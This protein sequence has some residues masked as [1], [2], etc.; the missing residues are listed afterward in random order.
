VQ[1]I[2]FDGQRYEVSLPWKEH[3]PPLHDHFVLCHKR[4]TNL[5]RRRQSPQLLKEYDAIIRDQLDKGIV[6]TVTEPALSVS[7]RV[8]YLPHHGV[9]R[10]DKATSKLRIVYDA[11]AK[12]TG[13]SLNDCLY[14]GPKFGQSI[15]DILLRFHLQKV[16]LTG[17][18]E[19][20]FLMVSV[21]ERDR[22]SLRFLWTANPNV[23]PPEIITLRFARVMFECLNATINHHLQTYRGADAAFVDKFLSSILRR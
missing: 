13:P 16:A 9:V 4:L 8:H 1:Q 14:T 18:I 3:H 10:Q 23:E 19:K 15:F 6:E 12:S 7:D 11:S 20:A 2:R 17:D 22:D 5:P 21:Q